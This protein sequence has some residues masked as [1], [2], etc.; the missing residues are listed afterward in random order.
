MDVYNAVYVN[1]FVDIMLF[2]LTFLLTRLCIK[3]IKNNMQHNIFLRRLIQKHIVIHCNAAITHVNA[4][5]KISPCPTLALLQLFI[6]QFQS[7]SCIFTRVSV[8]SKLKLKYKLCILRSL[9]SSE[10]ILFPLHFPHTNIL[11]L[12]NASTHFFWQ[13]H[14]LEYKINIRL[15]SSFLIKFLH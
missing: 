5:R 7:N 13:E 9:S 12:F 8:K 4:L 1:I 15:K 6:Q 14:K 3:Q 10:I 2:M 11:W